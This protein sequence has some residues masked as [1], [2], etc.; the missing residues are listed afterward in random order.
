MAAE[1]MRPNPAVAILNP[2]DSECHDQI[3][4]QHMTCPINILRVT[5]VHNEHRL[6]LPST[7]FLCSPPFAHDWIATL[8]KV[9]L[10]STVDGSAVTP[11]GQ[12]L[13]F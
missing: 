9:E 3:C 13:H 5:R 11:C 1:V 7:C 8:A 2:L 10:A 6:K 4:G 12:L